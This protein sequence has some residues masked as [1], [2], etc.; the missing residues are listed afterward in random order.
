MYKYALTTYGLNIQKHKRKHWQLIIQ[1]CITMIK[2]TLLNN[3]IRITKQ[4]AKSTVKKYL[5]NTWEDSSII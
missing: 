2:I 4:H 3:I 5:E 1:Q